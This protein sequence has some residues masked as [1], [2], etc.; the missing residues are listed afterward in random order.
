MLLLDDFNLVPKSLQLKPDIQLS[1]QAKCNK[2]NCNLN[3]KNWASSRKNHKHRICRTCMAAYKKSF[4]QNVKKE[5]IN[6]YGGKCNCCHESELI[7]LTID[8]IDGQGAKHRRDLGQGKVIYTW[9]KKNNYPKNNYQV[10]CFNCNF[11]KH[12]LGECPHKT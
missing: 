9:L 4:Y 7:F 11:A 12:V 1:M 2:C 5:V 6:H 10:L 8:H 3:K